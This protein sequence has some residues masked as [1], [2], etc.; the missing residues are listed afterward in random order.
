VAQVKQEDWGYSLPRFEE[1]PAAVGIG[2]DGTCL[3]M[4][5]DGWREAMVGTLAFFDADGERRRTVYLAATPE[6]GR[7]KFLARM[8]QEIGRAKA[9]FPG[10]RYVGIADGAGGDWDF[11]GRHTT[12]EVVGFWHA[13]EYRGQAA[14]HRLKHEAGGAEWV[15]KRLRA[16]ARERPWARDDEDVGR[17]IVYFENQ[18][19]AGRMDYAA[20][21]EAGA[22]IGSGVTEA[23]CKVV[24]KQRLCGSG[25]KWTEGGAAAVLSLRCLT[26]TA[27]R[28]GQFWAKVERWGFPIAA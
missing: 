26:H 22:P 1:P 25:M 20:R 8:E 9:K 21:V 5:E 11:L 17:A 4:A 7:A 28:W 6:H 15:L 10:A 3:L 16:L 27:E 12:A 2:P 14:G 24:V 13:A 18:S 19:S 23:A